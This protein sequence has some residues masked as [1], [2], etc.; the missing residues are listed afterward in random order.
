MADAVP[1]KHRWSARRH[2]VLLVNCILRRKDDF[3]LRD[4][5][6]TRPGLDAG[7]RDWF[8]KSLAVDYNEVTE[9]ERLNAAFVAHALVHTCV[10]MVDHF[11]YIRALRWGSP[12][13]AA[14]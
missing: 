14:T 6:L 11:T 13:S 4:A 7:D 3:L 10:A 1:K 8:W 12:R 5:T 2:L 9:E